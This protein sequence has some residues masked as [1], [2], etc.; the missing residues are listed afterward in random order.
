MCDSGSGGPPCGPSAL[1]L[2]AYA[3]SDTTSVAAQDR[4]LF[5]GARSKAAFVDAL[6]AAPATLYGEISP[7]GVRALAA[8]CALGRGD[9]FADLGS[10][11]GRAVSQMYIERDLAA[12][13]GVECD[14]RG[15]DG[16][17]SAAL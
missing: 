12:C 8:R 15:A 17:G 10:G 3:W 13:I 7:R 6:A 9:T 14:C 2:L 1:D 5:G 16:R 4:L 11:L